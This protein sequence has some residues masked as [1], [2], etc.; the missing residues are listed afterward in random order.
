MGR[1]DDFN[2]PVEKQFLSILFELTT[3][4]VNI[5]THWV[6][7][8]E[9]PGYYQLLCQYFGSKNV[10]SS[11]FEE[12]CT[13]TQDPKNKQSPM[14]IFQDLLLDYLGSDSRLLLRTINDVDK[15]IKRKQQLEK[16]AKK[17]PEWI[18]TGIASINRATQS[19]IEATQKLYNNPTRADSFIAQ[20]HQI[21][22]D[23]IEGVHINRVERS[24]TFATLDLIKNQLRENVAAFVNKNRKK[25]DYEKRLNYFIAFFD[26]WIYLKLKNPK[27]LDELP[28]FED[29]RKAAS[30]DDPIPTRVAKKIKPT[31]VVLT[32]ESGTN[33][34]KDALLQEFENM[35]KR[36]D[37]FLGMTR[38]QI[39]PQVRPM[40]AVRPNPRQ[41]FDPYPEYGFNSRYRGTVLYKIFYLYRVIHFPARSWTQT[42]SRMGSHRLFLNKSDRNMIKYGSKTKIMGYFNIKLEKELIPLL[43]FLKTPTDK[44]NDY[45][46]RLTNFKCFA[47]EHVIPPTSHNLTTLQLNATH[48]R[49]IGYGSSF[50][51]KPPS[52]TTSDLMEVTENFVHRAAVKVFMN[53]GTTRRILPWKKD[54]RT[55]ESVSAELEQYKAQ[56]RDVINPTLLTETVIT[57]KRPIRDNL[58]SEERKAL[59]SLRKMMETHD[60]MLVEADKNLGTCIITKS[61]YSEMIFHELKK[62]DT[63]FKVSAI[64]NPNDPSQN[65]DPQT[66]IK[67]AIDTRE[68]TITLILKKC[69]DPLSKKYLAKYFKAVENPII[70]TLKGMPKLHKKGDRM[71]IILPFC[72]HVL[73]DIHNFIAATLQPLAQRPNTA[74]ISSLELVKLFE[75]QKWDPDDFLVS[76]DLD[77]MYNRINLNLA[78][79]MIIRS[80]STYGKEF[81]MFGKSWQENKDAWVA[82]IE[83]AF[84]HCDFKFNDQIIQQIYGVAMGAPTGPVVAI[85]FINEILKINLPSLTDIKLAKMYIDDG[86][87]VINK[88]VKE[89]NIPKLLSEAIKYKD[90]TLNW[91]KPSIIIRRIRDLKQNPLNFLDIVFHS[92]TTHN[93]D[94]DPSKIIRNGNQRPGDQCNIYFTLYCKPLGSYSYLHDKSAHPDTCKK[95]IIFAEATRRLRICTHE[96]DFLV[97]L[98]DLAFKFMRRGYSLTEI[99]SETDKLNH[100]M[101]QELINSVL[102][103]INN[104][105][106]PSLNYNPFK[107]RPTQKE[108]T[109]IP[110]VLRYD[111]R[112]NLSLTKHLRSVEQKLNEQVF[113]RT[114]VEHIRVVCANRKN[115][116]LIKQLNHRKHGKKIDPNILK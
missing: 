93:P 13:A 1:Q 114:D 60:L 116:T 2:D 113:Q 30:D 58:N 96:E 115:K 81:F 12:I 105:R 110:F 52:L 69:N 107:E 61:R 89:E 91:D 53:G 59:Q 8:P 79:E 100:A 87:F 68:E 83:N 95:S 71:R 64:I 20:L 19:M 106:I 28:T 104:R 85:I 45:F 23:I 15:I 33:A 76:A 21:K 29:K 72:N 38:E 90:S 7:L 31:P 70:P 84:K 48:L 99:D 35:K 25:P 111:P 77:S 14:A 17:A 16:K 74:I 82:I 27:G 56:I 3:S 46:H 39:I 36:V 4:S 42:R 80:M 6:T 5:D 11:N 92:S 98:E 73:T 97:A 26:T 10:S 22:I 24:E 86:L 66:L 94:S 44:I 63:S 103:K 18:K 43:Y 65:C 109:I 9:E 62:L 102:S 54:N 34:K 32:T 49:L 47:S 112:I 78:T 108:E 88:N 41:R 55:F 75:G 51:S 101:R 40:E 37:E 67:R 57:G 50:I